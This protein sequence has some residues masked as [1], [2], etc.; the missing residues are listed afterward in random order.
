LIKRHV[1]FTALSFLV[2]S[3]SIFSQVKSVDCVNKAAVTH[4]VEARTLTINQSGK[5]SNFTKVDKVECVNLNE[6][7]VTFDYFLFNETKQI[8]EIEDHGFSSL[9]TDTNMIFKSG[10]KIFGV[11]A[12]ATCNG[13]DFLIDDK[14]R[15]WE[16]K[17]D[18]LK[19]IERRIGFNRLKCVDGVTKPIAVNQEGK[20]EYSEAKKN[21]EKLAEEERYIIN[22]NR[23]KQEVGSWCWAAVT[24]SIANFYNPSL[25]LSQ[26]QLANKAFNQNNCCENKQSPSCNKGFDISKSLK[27]Y[28]LFKKGLV[29]RY[30]ANV[31]KPEDV[32]P[33]LSYNEIKEECKNNRPLVLSFDMIKPGETT[34][35]NHFVTVAGTYIE[36]GKEMV[37]LLDPLNIGT[38][39]DGITNIE[40]SKMNTSY[41]P[42]HI[43]PNGKNDWVDYTGSWTQTI[44]TKKPTL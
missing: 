41:Q 22:I 7:I 27:D 1:L 10:N 35:F 38:Q 2:S 43:E 14:N 17:G 34:G 39:G 20:W 26:C 13:T 11:Q 21:W 42:N 30:Y 32:K 3:V 25:N 31:M 19:I 40:Y 29:H 4:D 33:V 9:L 18:G 28:N 24:A 15:L 44:F 36:N 16:D 5:I 37:R 8:F 6:F 12:S 23:I